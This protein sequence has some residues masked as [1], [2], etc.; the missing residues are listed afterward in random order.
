M[1]TVCE[2]NQC[3][4][5]QVCIN[6][7]HKDA[8]KIVDDIKACNAVIDETKCVNCGRCQTVCPT[9][10]PIEK[11]QPILWK[12]GWALDVGTRKAS[13][14]GGMAAAIQQAFIQSGGGVCS[15]KF[16]KGEFVF[17]F[18]LN[19][20]D[21]K[22]FVGSKYVKSSPGMVYRKVKDYLDAGQKILFVGL[23]CQCAAVKKYTNDHELLY[24]IDLI[25][26]GTPSLRTLQMFLKEKGYDMEQMSDIKFR[27]KAEWYLSDGHKGIEPY[28]VRDRYMIAFLKGLCY[29]QNCY[30]CQY[31]F[32]ERISDITLGDS[33]GST[34]DSEEQKKGISLVLCQTKKGEELL[35]QSTIHLEAVDVDTAVANNRQLR[36]PTQKPAEYDLFNATLNKKKNFNK[37]VG[38][39]YP[40]HC[41]R[42]DIKA[43]LVKL[44]LL[45]GERKPGAD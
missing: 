27:E 1:R 24:T 41:F 22:R 26:H 43:L 36:S 45:H 8:I 7:C 42:Q 40:K 3:S 12:Q 16:S 11:K 35:E 34:L 18:A 20:E 14:S 38:A 19:L 31:A 29:T 28:S 6:A 17:D 4:S 37:A 23:P 9:N 5:C 39:C 25:C 44:N 21:A 33:W 2:L 32:V 15:C 10:H 30:S 13:S